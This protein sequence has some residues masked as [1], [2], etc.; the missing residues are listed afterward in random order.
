MIDIP[1]S[2]LFQTGSAFIPVIT[3]QD[4]FLVALQKNA[5]VLG[6]VAT[7]AGM[8][9]GAAAGPALYAS[10]Q[11]PLWGLG[12][13]LG[14]VSAPAWVPIAGGIAGLV[15]AG[16]AVKITLDR[17]N[18]AK[19]RDAI[20]VGYHVCWVLANELGGAGSTSLRDDLATILQQYE[21]S[22]RDVADIKAH[23]PEVMGE[24][25]VG[26]LEY[27]FR[28]QI[29]TAA[30]A[31]C[32]KAG[33]PEGAAKLLHRAAERLDL[34][35]AEPAIRERCAQ[36]ATDEENLIEGM[37]FAC[38][39]LFSRVELPHSRE[40]L[41]S[42]G[43]WHPHQQRLERAVRI[44]DLVVLLGSLAATASGHPAVGRVIGQTW[45]GCRSAAL[46]YVDRSVDRGYAELAAFFTRE[47]GVKAGEIEGIRALFDAALLAA[48]GKKDEP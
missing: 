23:V 35:A 44:G 6:R 46:K 30:Y 1:S 48:L 17:V 10:L 27:D 25:R 20:R 40:F 24:V 5:S 15:V 37:F 45:N 31:I 18:Y 39:H 26:H 8:A 38:Q 7:A 42:L 11:G 32:A 28:A 34:V 12:A 3:S 16:S 4:D 2:L 19:Q 13:A 9:G 22:E 14:L 36:R 41:S 47:L 21:L 29:F 43:S 33:W